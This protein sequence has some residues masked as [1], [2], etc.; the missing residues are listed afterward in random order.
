[1]L[2]RKAPSTYTRPLRTPSSTAKQDAYRTLS[3]ETIVTGQ[4]NVNLQQ[5]L[6]MSTYRNIY[7]SPIA[8]TSVASTEHKKAKRVDVG[9][10]ELETE[11]GRG[12]TR[13]KMRSQTKEEDDIS[14]D[15]LEQ[16]DIKS[17]PRNL[18]MQEE[19]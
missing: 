3:E 6:S 9:R 5:I 7:D 16:Q 11:V 4:E 17:I 1:M 8:S 19:K 2:S 13:T 10:R 15:Y 12:H 18:R 14:E